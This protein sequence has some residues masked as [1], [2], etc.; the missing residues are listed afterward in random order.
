MTKEEL[1]ILK[2][3]VQEKKKDSQVQDFEND[4]KWRNNKELLRTYSLQ[5]KNVLVVGSEAI[6]KREFPLGTIDCDI[7]TAA[8][9]DSEKLVLEYLKRDDNDTYGKYKHF[10]EVKDT[11]SLFQDIDDLLKRIDNYW[12]E[13][14]IDLID[15]SLRLLLESKCFRLVIT[16]AFDP[17]LEYALKNIWGDDNL[18]VKNIHGEVVMRETD[19]MTEP[20]RKSEFYDINP[21]L[22]YAF[23]KAIAGVP[24]NVYA[25]TDDRKIFTIDCWFGVRQPVNLLQYMQNKD[26]IAVGCKFEN[27]LFRFFWYLLGKKPDTSPDNTFLDSDCKTGSVA[28][29]LSEEANDE[30]K[31]KLFL[32]KKKQIKYFEDSRIF[33]S[34]LAPDLF[35]ED[36]PKVGEIFISYASEDF[37]TAR[38]I[39]DYLLS[40][41]QSVWFDIRLR[42]GD[43]YDSDIEN[44]I[45]QSDIFLPILS[46][47][48]KKD[49]E[50]NNN[51]YYRK[52][53]NIANEKMLK[54]Q[55]ENKLF[56]AIPVVIED[57]AVNN[58]RYHN[59][60]LVPDCI[61]KASCFFTTNEHA[62]LSELFDVINEQ[63]EKWNKNH[64]K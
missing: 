19:I 33:M 41:Q 55:E 47:Q 45:K 62:S 51:R 24:D 15:P 43:R 30:Q 32:K 40:K 10:S 21:T 46:N 28:I 9:G 14:A 58:S 39:Y 16:T 22:F 44:G 60:S 12:R 50:N 25:I 48:T 35:I 57:Y 29:M 53:W 23:G 27:W 5:G 7:L 59:E 64:P 36:Q 1:E 52:E 54:S 61:F 34:L 42:A 6:L 49:L 56:L 37:G 3:A 2:K 11:E 18:S 17:I 4:L 31:T 13:N 8:K 63:K 38:K 20:N 26:V